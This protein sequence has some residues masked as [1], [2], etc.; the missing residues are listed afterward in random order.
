VWIVSCLLQLQWD[1]V[2]RRISSESPWHRAEENLFREFGS[3]N[4]PTIRSRAPDNLSNDSWPK[5]Y[6]LVSRDRQQTRVARFF[7][8]H[9]TKTGRNVPNEHECTKLS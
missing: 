7:L 5:V 3:R 9:G 1:A 4:W 8:V 6:T 2:M